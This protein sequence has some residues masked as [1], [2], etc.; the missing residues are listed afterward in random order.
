MSLERWAE[1]GW[2]RGHVASREEIGNL[3]ALIERDLADSAITGLTPDWRLN[4]AYNA[5]LQCA[6]TALAASGYR[7]SRE[8]H[9][10]RTIGSLE[11]TVGADQV[12]VAQLDM[13]R[14]KRNVSDYERT[15]GVSETEALE[16]RQFALELRDDLLSW[17]KAEHPELL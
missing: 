16:M 8:A 9:H 4:I 5:A 7:A 14:R 11:F 2:L 6:T 17:L 10:V 1:K 15:G 12:K 3:L 13:F